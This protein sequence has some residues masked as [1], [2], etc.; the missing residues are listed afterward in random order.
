MFLNTRSAVLQTISAVNFVNWGDNNILKAGKA[1]ANQKQFWGDFL[2]LMNSDYL[3]E[4]RDGLK[5]NV[6]ESEIADAVEG[7]KNKVNAAISYLLNKGFV[8]T[9]YA[10][11]FAIAS[12]GATFYRN[13]IESLVEQGMDRKAA[14]EQAFNDFRA[15]AEEN[16]QSSSPSK[17]SQQQRSLIGRIILQ[18]GNTQL[19]YVRIQKRAVQ[20]LVNKR[21][22]W[23]SNI[24]KIVY[25]GAMQN[26]LFNAL[27]SGLAWALFDDDEDDE[28]LTEKNKEQKF[29]RTINGAIDSQL[30][31]LGIQ[32]AVIAGVKNAL[33][34]IAEQAD[35][36]SPKFEE[37]LDDLLSIAP[38]LG[39]K[40][41]KLKSA[42]RTVSW[43]RKEIKEKGFSMDNPAYLAG[44]QV[45]SAAFNIPLDRAV[46]KMNNMRNILNP[47]TENWQKVALALGWSGWDVGLPYFGLAEEKPV[48][49][50]TEK[51]T[52]KLFDL[53]KSDQVKM[54]LDLGL[55]K[56][57]IRALTK[58][59]QRV[60]E[61]IKLQNK[62]KDGKDKS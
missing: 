62:K 2:T 35:K 45:I 46:M 58:E 4:R 47:A 15:I 43:N 41:R 11:S 17:I 1:F 24:S 57:Q 53:N 12:G 39:S 32:G 33:M 26:L 23:K 59:E 19:Q 18:F 20:D 27:Q 13:R 5:I 38:A 7:S 44:A 55:T 40:I 8:F 61:I 34:T 48:L 3:L 29:E 60:Q 21:G 36:K 14:E 30:K 54:L 22:D 16:Q 51:Q 49:T 42:A 28:E 25:Y 10:D 9:R 56:K 6:S 31:G 37:A 52:K 50:E